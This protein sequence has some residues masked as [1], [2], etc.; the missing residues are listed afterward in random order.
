MHRR[1]WRVKRLSVF[2]PNVRAIHRVRMGVWLKSACTLVVSPLVVSNPPLVI[3]TYLFCRA[4]GRNK[5]WHICT[6]IHVFFLVVGESPSST[7]KI[8]CLLKKAIFWVHLCLLSLSLPNQVQHFSQE[9]AHWSPGSERHFI[10]ISSAL[11]FSLHKAC[12]AVTAINF[13]SLAN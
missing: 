12:Q 7:R 1:P 2:S 10:P 13:P 11:H 5:S 6:N 8:Y 9:V 4:G 3:Q